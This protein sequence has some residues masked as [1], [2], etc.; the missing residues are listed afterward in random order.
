MESR[1]FV[2]GYFF[3]YSAYWGK[4]ALG[5]YS[6]VSAQGSVDAIPNPPSVG[7]TFQKA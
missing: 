5:L 2:P 4:W 6:S 7:T 1:I 3:A